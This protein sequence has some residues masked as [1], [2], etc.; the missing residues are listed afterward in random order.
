MW[1]VLL[2]PH[3]PRL[4]PWKCHCPCLGNSPYRPRRR[5][6]F[7]STDPAVPALGRWTKQSSTSSLLQELVVIF[8][9][10]PPH[11]FVAP[12]NSGRILHHLSVDNR[13]A[14]SWLT[15]HHHC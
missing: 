9:C 5:S 15:S 7:P 1:R 12:C 2:Y 13:A 4:G 14:S 10:S 8:S 6:P 3:R 11:I